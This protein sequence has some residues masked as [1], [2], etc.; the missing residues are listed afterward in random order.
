MMLLARA[1]RGAGRHDEA[2]EFLARAIVAGHRRAEREEATSLELNKFA[3]ILLT[4]EEVDL[5]DPDAARAFA[6][7]AVEL[8]EGKEPAP[9]GVLALAYRMTGDFDQAIDTQRHVIALLPHGD[10][11]TRVA[12]E[13]RLVEYLRAQGDYPAADSVLDNYLARV[14][15]S[16]GETRVGVVRRMIDLALVLLDGGQHVEY[17][18]FC[19]VPAFLRPSRWANDDKDIARRVVALGAALVK[20]SRYAEAA[21]ILYECVNVQ[22]STLPQGDWRTYYTKSVLGE[23]LVGQDRFGE[24]ESLL[25]EAYARLKADP[26]AL[27]AHIREAHIRVIQLYEAWDAAEPGNGYAEKAAEWRAQLP[28][29]VRW[30]SLDASETPEHSDEIGSD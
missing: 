10:S 27:G 2:H 13:L 22:E 23:A 28:E 21:A 3:W 12:A 11:S 25:L 14:R 7:R 17:E 26:T 6:V 20:Q 24:G 15:E 4:C 5:R 29:S 30:D 9:L 8:S 18:A 1:F 19:R 16:Y